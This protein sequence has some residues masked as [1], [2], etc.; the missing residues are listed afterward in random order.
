[1]PF[2]RFALLRSFAVFALIAVAFPA[3]AR[4]PP[5]PSRVRGTIEANRGRTISGAG[6]DLRRPN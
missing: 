2:H 1:M 5:T 3:I 4:Q 6:S